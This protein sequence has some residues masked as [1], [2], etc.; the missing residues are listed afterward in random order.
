[1]VNIQHPV[2]SKV[3]KS[4]GRSNQCNLRE[5]QNILALYQGLGIYRSVAKLV[6]R[7]ESCVRKIIKKYNE[8]G[9]LMG[10]QRFGRRRVTTARDDHKIVIDMQR[11]R[12]VTAHQI[13]QDNPGI[14]CSEQT[15]RRRIKASGEFK[16]YWKTK[17]PS[18]SN[19][20]R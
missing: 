7:N 20:N 5:K 9:S 15:V 8:T 2:R 14:H 10:V 11:D 12:G 4:S 18:I 16:S 19:M 1:M 3:K 13:L 6:G 17:K